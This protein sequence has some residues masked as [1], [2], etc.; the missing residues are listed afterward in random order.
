MADT[1]STSYLT[2]YQ[3]LTVQVPYLDKSGTLQPGAAVDYF[4][5]GTQYDA[6][7]GTSPRPTTAESRAW[8]LLLLSELFV[9][10]FAPDGILNLPGPSLI[11][12]SGEISLGVGY[13]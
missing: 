8:E 3:P 6:A 2:D 1:Y 12:G 4:V 9:I 11:L 13:A 10:V 5:T 7:R